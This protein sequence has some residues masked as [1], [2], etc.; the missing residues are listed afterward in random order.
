V[1]G[2]TPQKPDSL[3]EAL[4]VIRTH[5]FVDLTQAF[6]PGIPHWHGVPDEVRETLS[7]YDQGIGTQGVGLPDPPGTCSLA[8]GGRMSTP[9]HFIK[10]RRTRDQIDVREMV[11]PLVVI[12][13]QPGLPGPSRSGARQWP[14]ARAG[15]PGPFRPPRSPRDGPGRSEP[16]LAR[17]HEPFQKTFF[18]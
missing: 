12:D 5:R 18:F 1:G 3:L 11:L 4:E 15:L 16:A 9:A 13:V 17:H 10:G 2:I 8:S 6:A 7:H 14:G